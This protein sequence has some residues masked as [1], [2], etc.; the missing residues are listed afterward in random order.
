MR[1]TNDNGAEPS[2]CSAQAHK[3]RALTA[4]SDVAGRRG[5]HVLVIFFVGKIRHAAEH[6]KVFV[7]AVPRRKVEGA[8]RL[9]DAV[10]LIGFLL[11]V[12]VGTLVLPS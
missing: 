7:D 11:E 8:V 9:H 2:E 12:V 4:G 3:E 10:S 6:F 5:H 1:S